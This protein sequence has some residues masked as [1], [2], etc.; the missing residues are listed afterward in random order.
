MSNKTNIMFPQRRTS[1]G[2]YAR[3]SETGL[4][5]LSSHGWW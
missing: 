4:T 5:L 2:G 3:T 1:Y